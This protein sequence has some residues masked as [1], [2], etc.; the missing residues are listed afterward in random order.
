MVIL[1]RNSAK[2]RPNMATQSAFGVFNEICLSSALRCISGSPPGSKPVDNI[3]KFVGREDV[4]E[5][6][7]RIRFVADAVF[8][9]TGNINA[10]SRRNTRLNILKREDAGSLD[11]MIDLRLSMAVWNKL[12]MMR[13]QLR[14]SG[15]H[16]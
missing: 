9:V 15:A 2:S 3:G 6:Q 1:W 10:G 8:G 5:S 7:H 11:D 13:L 4:K 16:M 12:A 14:E